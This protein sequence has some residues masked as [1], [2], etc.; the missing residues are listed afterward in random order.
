MNI[1]D[2]SYSMMSL[3]FCVYLV[4]SIIIFIPYVEVLYILYSFSGLFWS[5]FNQVRFCGKQN[6][7]TLAEKE[8]VIYSQV[9]SNPGTRI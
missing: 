3:W 6:R 7:V 8:I 4:V 1:G 9:P 2:Y 5:L